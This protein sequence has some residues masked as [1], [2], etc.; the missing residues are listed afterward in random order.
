MSVATYSPNRLVNTING[1]QLSGFGDSD[2][3]TIKLDEDK[4]EKF[5]SVDGQVAR[6]FNVANT[7]TFTYTLNQTSEANTILSSLLKADTL[8][9]TGDLTFSVVVRDENSTGTFYLGTRCWIKGMPESGYNKEIGTRE[10]VIEA[11]DIT[12]FITGSD[13]GFF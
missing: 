6:S 11:T 1:V 8:S 10:W 5:V 4:F 2:I 3:V 7:G 9:N 12:Y 13:A